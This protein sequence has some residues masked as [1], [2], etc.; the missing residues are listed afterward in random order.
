MITMQGDISVQDIVNAYQRF[1]VGSELTDEAINNIKDYKHCCTFMGYSAEHIAG[2]LH[3]L[4]EVNNW[5]M[6]K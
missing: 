3:T 4:S 1:E 6:F 5:R 2:C